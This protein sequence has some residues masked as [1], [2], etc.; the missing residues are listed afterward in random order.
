MAKVDDVM[1]LLREGKVFE[2]MKL[3]DRVE[4]RREMAEQLTFFAGTLDWLKSKSYSAGLI[5]LKAVE[6]DPDYA[7]AHYNLGVV[8]TDPD[9]LKD[10]KDYFTLAER[11]YRIV[12]KLD[13]SFAPAHYNLALLYYFTGRLA[14]CRMEYRKAVELDP[15]E[16]KF[17]ELGAILEN[18]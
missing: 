5:L 3:A 11:E 15:S 7:L 4:D 13:P 8:L 1:A 6:V 10:H 17:R 2:A 16:F 18:S 9:L 14:D 12:I